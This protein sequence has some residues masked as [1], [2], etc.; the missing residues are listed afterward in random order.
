MNIKIRSE[1]V[2]V[3]P[4]AK[5][6]TSMVTVPGTRIFTENNIS[7]LIRQLLPTNQSGFVISAEK[8][9]DDTFN[10]SF[11]IYG[12][13]FKIF[14]LNVQSFADDIYAYII[15]DNGEIYGS[16]K[17]DNEVYYYEGLNICGKS[18]LPKDTNN[19]VKSIKILSKVNGEWK[20]PNNF[21]TTFQSHIGGIDG[22][23]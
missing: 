9:T 22:K 5:P 12:Y 8:I 15:I 19:I 3:F 16:D 23:R 4:I 20:C 17:L 14:G 18:G 6:R 1:N 13:Y 2:E 7:N 11:N 10:I 21:G